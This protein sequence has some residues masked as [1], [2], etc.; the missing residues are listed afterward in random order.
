MYKMCRSY[1]PV[2]SQGHIKDE[3]GILVQDYQH[4]CFESNTMP[5]ATLYMNEIT[6]WELCEELSCVML[7]QSDNTYGRIYGYTIKIDNRIAP[8]VFE[9][10]EED[11][12]MEREYCRHDIDSLDAYRYV[13]EGQRGAG[14]SNKVL[15]P[16]P[17]R[18]IVN[19]GAVILFWSDGDK[20]IVKRAEDDI[21][22]PVKGFLWAYFQKHSGLSKTKANKYLRDIDKENEPTLTIHIDNANL[23]S[24]IKNIFKED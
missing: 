13:V 7:N 24:F 15:T 6:Y 9:L 12:F 4:R 19:D 3:L 23:T 10:R 11:N 2:F 5:K 8:H 14:K 22:D 17:T 1:S 16:L 20:T 21:F 18:Y